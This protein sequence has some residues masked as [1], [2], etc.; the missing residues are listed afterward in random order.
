MKRKALNA[1]A[2]SSVLLL[3]LSACGS[4]S[5]STNTTPDTQD[6][7]NVSDNTATY[8]IGESTPTESAQEIRIDVSNDLIEADQYYAN[9]RT[10]DA[11]TIQATELTDAQCAIEVNVEY[12]TGALE[13][14][15]KHDHSNIQSD[16]PDEYTLNTPS[17]DIKYY[18]ATGLTTQDNFE[19]RGFN[20][21]HTQ[22]VKKVDCATSPTDADTSESIKFRTF[23]WREANDV[24]M[25]T[26]GEANAPEPLPQYEGV[27]SLVDQDFAEVEFTVMAN[28]DIQIISSSVEGWT[29]DSNGMWLED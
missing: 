26:R 1:V 29:K 9:H 28:G 16:G 14:L 8:T 6:N 23:E 2:I 18:R 17:S 24:W 20:Q 12:A 15:A 10:V 4:D 22:H 11:L 13:E 19:D 25:E 3:A 27:K 21:D 5:E 7:T